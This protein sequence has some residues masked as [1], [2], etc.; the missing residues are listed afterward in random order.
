MNLHYQRLRSLERKRM[1]A[2]LPTMVVMEDLDAPGYYVG[3]GAIR[4]SEAT[5]EQLSD[6]NRI[7]RIVYDADAVKRHPHES[8]RQLTWGDDNPMHDAAE[9]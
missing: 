9:R 7:V 3:A 2:E 4:Y 1:A 8:I 5:L 6:S